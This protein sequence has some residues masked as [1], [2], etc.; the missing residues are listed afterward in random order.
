MALRNKTVAREDLAQEVLQ[1]H[2]QPGLECATVQSGSASSRAT[3]KPLPLPPA[4]W[5]DMD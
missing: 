2:S 5:Y 1:L 3:L 4:G